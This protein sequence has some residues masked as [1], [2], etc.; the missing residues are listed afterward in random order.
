MKKHTPA[1]LILCT[2]ALAAC[3]NGKQAELEKQIQQQQQ[4]IS[5]LQAQA[6]AAA[7]QTVY[8]LNPEAV[9]E[10]LSPE[11][12]EKGKNGETVT[13]SDGQQYVYDN[14]TGSWLLQSLIGAAAGAFIGNALANRF[15]RAPVSP[16]TQQ[17]RSRYE[18]EY[19]GKRAAA[20]NTLRP[21]SPAAAGQQANTY[22]PTDRAQPNHRKP[23]SGGFGGFGRRR[24]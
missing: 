17:V 24:R 15:S 20:P 4:Q 14:S 19:K 11:A 10:T 13:G 21:R 12:Q 6:S 3:D 22:R 1:A 8:Q 16:A 23:R 18:Q 5:Q 7:D 2:L 9:N